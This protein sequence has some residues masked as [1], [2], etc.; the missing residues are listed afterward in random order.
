[1]LF[2]SGEVYNVKMRIPIVDE[3]DNV[4]YFKDSTERDR[5]KEITQISA[6]WVVN[7]KGEFLLAKRSKNKKHHPNVWG[8]SVA[9]SVEEGE[10]Y[11]ENIKKE[12]KEEIGIDAV[13]ITIGPK[14]RVSSS[15]EYFCQYFFVK[16]PSSTAFHLQESEVDEVKWISLKEL[17]DWYTKS[18]E[19]FTPSFSKSFEVIKN[20]EN[21]NKKT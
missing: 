19:E 12:A 20:Y 4:L 11:E 6:L 10:S 14:K 15:H 1:M 21:Q 9:G 5:I 7:E 3:Q 18:S 2:W 13:E 8:P 16:I 17:K